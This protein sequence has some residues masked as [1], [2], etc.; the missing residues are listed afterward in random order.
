MSE[1][2][3]HGNMEES[4]NSSSPLELGAEIWFPCFPDAS[5]AYCSQM[6]LPLPFG[7]HNILV[8]GVKNIQTYSCV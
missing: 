4:P 8:E 6:L 1:S 2:G 3:G 5:H 7:S